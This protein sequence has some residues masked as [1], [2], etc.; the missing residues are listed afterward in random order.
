[1]RKLFLISLAL[2]PCKQLSGQKDDWTTSETYF[3]VYTFSENIMGLT[4]ELSYTHS[5]QVPFLDSVFVQIATSDSI[6]YII[7]QQVGSCIPIDTNGQFKFYKNI[8]IENKLLADIDKTFIVYCT[9]GIVKRE[10]KDVVFALDECTS[11]IIVFRFDNIDPNKYGQ[12]MFCSKTKMNLTFK[13][14]A[15]IDK[16]IESFR[17]SQQYDYSDSIKSVSYAQMDSLYFAY[18]DNFKWNKQNKIDNYF[19]GRAVYVMR[20]DEKVYRKWSL[21]LDLFGIPCD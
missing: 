10:I 9:K 19:P 5:T 16:K 15:S 7:S 20:Q 21:S 12:P 1:M 18:N 14:S 3:Q 6:G 13:N 17:Q 2:L 11:N 4:V 8:K